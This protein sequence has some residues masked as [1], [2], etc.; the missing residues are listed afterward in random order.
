MQPL[1]NCIGPTIRIG[2]EI[3][4]LPYAGFFYIRAAHLVSLGYQANL[5]LGPGLLQTTQP[6][7]L[8]IYSMFKIVEHKVIGCRTAHLVSLGH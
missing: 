7:R 4:C 1:P 3:R 6:R 2:R 8:T 5:K